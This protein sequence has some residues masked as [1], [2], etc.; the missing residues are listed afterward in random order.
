MSTLSSSTTERPTYLILYSPPDPVTHKLWC[1]DC[2][3]VEEP[4]RQA[5]NANGG[6]K[7]IIHWVGQR[8]EWRKPDNE[9]RARWNVNNVPTILKLVEVSL[10]RVPRSLGQPGLL[11]MTWLDVHREGQGSRPIS[12]KRYSQGGPAREILAILKPINA[13]SACTVRIML[14]TLS[15]Y[16]WA[17]MAN[18]VE[19][20]QIRITSPSLELPH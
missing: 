13:S 2:R 14:S 8:D 3:A 6:P 17:C 9:A 16:D 19:M 10:L 5:F 15:R 18:I 11:I 7:G 20:I 12:R 1:P 4:V